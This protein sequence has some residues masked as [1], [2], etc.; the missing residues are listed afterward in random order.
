MNGTPL[1]DR[2][3]Q[4]PTRYHVTPVAGTEDIH[5]LTPAPGEITAEGT[6]INKGVLYSDETKALYPDGVNNPNDAFEYLVKNGEAIIREYPAALDITAGDVCDVV[7]GEASYTLTGTTPADYSG[8]IADCGGRITSLVFD[9]KYSIICYYYSNGMYFAAVNN[10]DGSIVA[11]SNPLTNNTYY[12]P[13]KIEKINENT[14]AVLYNCASQHSDSVGFFKFDSTTGTVSHIKSVNLK[15]NGSYVTMA[16]FCRLSDTK[17]LIIQNYPYTALYAV[18]ATI[19]EDGS[20]VTIG[21]TFTKL[22][23]VSGNVAC[24]SIA[25]DVIE[26]TGDQYTVIGVFHDSGTSNSTFEIRT[27]KVSEDTVTEIS[28]SILNVSNIKLQASLYDPVSIFADES[29]RKAY[30]PVNAGGVLTIYR[31]DY[32][33]NGSVSIDETYTYGDIITT[34][35]QSRRFG[36]Y[37]YVAYTETSGSNPKILSLAISEDGALREL[38]DLTCWS[39]GVNVANPFHFSMNDSVGIITDYIKNYIMLEA[40]NGILGYDIHFSSTQS[41]ALNSAAVGETVRLA[42]D[43]IAAAPLADGMEIVSNGVAGKM[44]GDKLSVFPEWARSLGV[45]IETGTYTGTGTYGSNNPNSLTFSFEP[46]LVIIVPNGSY[47]G[48]CFVLGAS[49][50]QIFGLSSSSVVCTFS[51]NIISWYSTASS[52]TTNYQ[53]NVSGILYKYIAIG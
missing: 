50:A 26:N 25:L 44:I 21:S 16:G 9:D 29:N 18:I 19:S 38:S 37:I 43:G 49:T 32:A 5:E 40:K 39:I 28:D 14:I 12:N 13:L 4:Y 34:N 36:D 17:V 33:A 15:S 51:G 22:E 31:L 41:I 2:N 3:V 45:K 30:F 46:K 42:F 24:G 48:G 1:T 47:H 20:S 7:D 23:N 11:T 53:L 35:V 52:G 6:L 27:I 10:S 8:T